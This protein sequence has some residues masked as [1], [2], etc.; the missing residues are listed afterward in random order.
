MINKFSNIE[1]K[2]PKVLVLISFFIVVS[3]L[4]PHISMQ[5]RMKEVFITGNKKV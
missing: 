4:Q 5:K 2:N 3:I 1:I